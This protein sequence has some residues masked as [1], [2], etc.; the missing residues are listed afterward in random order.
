MV[1][2]R[3]LRD[4]MNGLTH[5]VGAGL[6][7]VGLILL[8]I[9]ACT[10]VRPWHL[11]TFSLFGAGLVLL[12]TASTLYH[13]LPLSEAGVRRLR[14]LDH[15]MIF[16]LIA[17]TYTPICLIPLRG[18]WGWSLFGVIWGLALAGI[19]MKLCWLSAPRRLST[20]IYLFMGW[21]CLAA[22]WPMLQTMPPGAFV[23]LAVGGA[24][25]TLGGLVYALK[26]PDPWPGLLGFHE[27]FHL[28]VMGGSLA[29]FWVMYA[30]LA[31]MD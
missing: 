3:R 11:V 17:A 14:R 30:Y 25:Y 5:C 24:S 10:P 4:P 26:K 29:H 23:W 20:G 22:I 19:A 15:A 13:W 2:T 16:V 31:R 28:F 18:P 7:V 12:Y 27:I 1:R 21:L 9:E 8:V 6:S